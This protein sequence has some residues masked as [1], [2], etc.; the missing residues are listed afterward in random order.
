M[1]KKETVT[2]IS[3][4]DLNL[5]AVPDLKTME[6]GSETELK[7]TSFRLG[8][9]GQNNLPVFKVALNNL[10]STDDVE[11]ATVFHTLWL[12]NSSDLVS[13]ANRKRRDLVR[14]CTA[15]SIDAEE[16]TDYL[17]TAQST[18]NIENMPQFEGARGKTSYCILK[19]TEYEGT[20]RNEISRLVS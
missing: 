20:F 1:A 6:S 2:S 15:F 8:Y 19:E 4:L 11:Y 10:S 17:A 16:L 18:E 7:I 3:I 12:P 14:F 13:Q 5:G 9:V